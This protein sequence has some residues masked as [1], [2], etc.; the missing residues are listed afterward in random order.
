MTSG[1]RVYGQEDVSSGGRASG[2]VIVRGWEIVAAGG[3]TVNS[4]ITGSGGLEQLNGGTADGTLIESGGQANVNSGAVMS[5]STVG[6]G[7]TLILG[8]SGTLE[9]MTIASGGFEMVFSAGVVNGEVVS[10]GG[11]LFG[12]GGGQTFENVTVASGGGLFVYEEVSSGQVYSAQAETAQTTIS[13]ITLEVGADPDVYGQVDGGGTLYLGSGMAA[14]NMGVDGTVSGPGTMLATGVT[15]DF[16]TFIGVSVGN[17]AFYSELAVVGGSVSGVDIVNGEILLQ[18]GAWAS[19]VDVASGSELNVGNN[20]SVN[21]ATVAGFLFDD[22]WASNIDLAG[23]TLEVYS[24]SVLNTVSGFGTLEYA[25]GQTLSGAV[26]A[27]ANIIYEVDSG[28]TA[29]GG[30]VTSVTTLVVGSAGAASGVTVAGELIVSGTTSNTIL[31]GGTVEVVSGG[32]LSGVSGSG[33]IVYGAGETLSNHAFNSSV[34]VFE[35]ASG[36]QLDGGDVTSVSTLVVEAGAVA[37]G[38][39][40]AGEMIVSGTASHTILQGGELEVLG[41][42]ALAGES[43]GGA[44]VFGAGAVASGAIMNDV[45]ASFTAAAGAQLDGGDVAAGVVLT[46]DAGALASGVT[47]EGELIV[48][49][50][51]SNTHLDYGTLVEMGGGVLVGATGTG[52]IEYGGGLTL[53]GAVFN[54]GNVVYEIGPGGVMNA[55]SVTS[56]STLV[57]E[58]GAVVSGVTVAGALVVYGTAS[59]TNLDYGTLVEMGGGILVAPPAPGPSNTAAG[60]CSMARSSTPATWS[61]RSAPAG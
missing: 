22:G 40:V 11:Y 16:G 33:T 37:S 17:A 30:S 6:L 61:M 12:N 9:A 42:G 15:S 5:G 53:N 46:V 14:Y 28:A 31:A 4:V 20:T 18:S 8:S 24:G 23:G 27:N 49:G 36:A 55:G 47:V 44:V 41:N 21:G 60:W 25:G 51:A 3:V 29:A 10:S 1:D 52:A 35:A 34:V 59:N 57:V 54:A 43:G 58:S 26:F 38:V 39:T 19:G 48:Y 45:S 56:V 32:T 50:T 2:S 7:G 13:G